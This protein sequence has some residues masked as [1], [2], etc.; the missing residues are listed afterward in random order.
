MYL[1]TTEIDFET[2]YKILIGSVVPRPI[3]WVSTTSKAG[4]NN[5]APF[6]FFNA[7][8]SAPPMIVFSAGLKTVRTDD[9]FEVAPK[10]TL[11][12]IKDT[13]EFVVNIVSRHL[14]EKMN[15]TSANY[16]PEVSEFEAV[17]LTATASHVVSPPRVGESLVSLECKLY[18]HI[19][20]GKEAGAG[21]LVIGE[22]VCFHV[23]DNV[24]KNG[25]ID[26]DLLD[27]VGRLAGISYCTVKD[28]F[29]IARPK[30]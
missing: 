15:Q 21:N 6:S 11:K 12:N 9:G 13:N 17:G 14:V 30:L 22:V 28:R 24:Y 23:D 7:V 1:K 18:Q 3:A 10:D 2:S 27:P 4:I 5:L 16:P 19:E 26:I 8:S 20:F 29:D 25:H